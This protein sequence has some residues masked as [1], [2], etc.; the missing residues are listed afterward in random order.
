RGR[1]LYVDLDRCGDPYFVHNDGFLSWYERWL[2]ELLWGYDLSWFGNGLPGRE[3]DM[4]SALRRNEDF[5][6]R[7]TAALETLIRIPIL[8]P[9]TTVVVREHLR[10]P[11]AKVRCLATALLGK[12]KVVEAIADV[13]KATRDSSPEVRS[14]AIACLA[15][16]PGANWEPIARAA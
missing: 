5:D 4:R 14:S 7:H 15:K 11:S 12:H 8:Q 3:G 10:H 2:D 13:E 16:M 1:V 9:E 6:G